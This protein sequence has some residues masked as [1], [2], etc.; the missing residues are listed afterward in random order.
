MKRL[1]AFDW[2]YFHGKSHFE[3]DGTQ[4]WLVFQSTQKY[5]K[6]VSTNESNI[7]SSKSKGL[8][9]E[10][11]QPS[12]TSNKLLNPSLNF[13]GTKARVKFNGDYLKQEKKIHLIMEK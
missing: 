3:D 9:N 6:T 12:A 5:F 13:V 10:S 11:I 8:S 1:E 7:L 4:N 2:I